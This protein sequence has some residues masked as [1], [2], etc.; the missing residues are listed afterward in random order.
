METL[1]FLLSGL[2]AAITLTDWRRGLLVCVVVGFLQ[3]PLRKL[4]P[5]EPVYLTGLVGVSFGLTLVSAFARGKIGR[6]A[7]LPGWPWL[8]VAVL[9]FVGV[10]GLQALHTYISFGNLALAGI[11]LLA[12]LVPL[13]AAL[14]GYQFA[15]GS[16]GARRL[17][18]WYVL[19]SSAVSLSVYLSFLGL[20]WRVFRQ[21]GPGLVVFS[22]E[23][24]LAVYPGLLR[25]PEVAAWH[26]ATGV[27]FLVILG[28]VIRNLPGRFLIGSLACYLIGAGLLTGRRKML[29][30]VALFLGAYGFL[31]AW[32]RRG[33]RTV[34]SLVLLI[35]LVA[36]VLTFQVSDGSFRD[37]SF[38]PYVRH[39]VSG[40]GA[41]LPRF[42]SL[43]VGSTEWAVSS[44]GWL[45]AGAGTGSQGAQHFG[46]GSALVGGAAEGGLGKVL[47]ELGV[48]GFVAFLWLGIAIGRRLWRLLG[49]VPATERECSSLSYGL[50]AFLVANMATFV[51]A[52]QVYGD[53][54]VL[55]MLG[56]SLG[57]AFGTARLGYLR[58]EL[59]IL[60]QQ[61]EVKPA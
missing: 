42:E 24:F 1:S 61:L 60:W 21:V 54:F 53:L 32:S 18:F 33:A 48:P 10:V 59:A 34:A 43:G 58:H 39:G 46:G 23:Q 9:V 41:A 20:D 27:C 29:V 55:L 37:Q 50:V 40:F 3:D 7:R 12:Y 45:G 31:L 6:L 17:L 13:P 30:E 22:Q 57:L 2:G 38:Q 14:I 5:G 15:R 35:G 36:A 28:T 56:W 11:G 49:S 47:T 44:H 25:S 52:S 19:L 16:G 8:R 51:V 26:A 4:I